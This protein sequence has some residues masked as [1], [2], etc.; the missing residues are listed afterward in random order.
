M[1]RGSV[2]MEGPEGSVEVLSTQEEEGAGERKV[3]G[4][5]SRFLG[6]VVVP[7]EVIVK[8]EVEER[9][10]GLSGLRGGIV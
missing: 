7:G 1:E 3:G 6:L 4:V 2:L 10:G 8:V 9:R 5:T